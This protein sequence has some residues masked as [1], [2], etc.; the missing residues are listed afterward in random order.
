GLTALWV[1][2]RFEELDYC[3]GAFLLEEGKVVDRGEPQ[4]L[5]QRLIDS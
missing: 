2:H 4:R 1:T 5:K 3:D